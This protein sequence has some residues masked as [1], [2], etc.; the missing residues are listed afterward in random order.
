[1]QKFAQNNLADTA[2]DILSIGLFV[3]WSDTPSTAPSSTRRIAR[4]RGCAARLEPGPLQR[5][6]VSES[7]APA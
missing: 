4:A 2:D 6:R 7:R 3:Y 1:M 5:D